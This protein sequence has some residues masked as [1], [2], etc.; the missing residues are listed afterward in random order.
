MCL[1]LHQPLANGDYDAEYVLSGKIVLTRRKPHQRPIVSVYKYSNPANKYR[2]RKTTVDGIEFHSQKEASRYDML[3][4]LERSG[5]ISDLV[6]QP[7]FVIAEGF[8]HDGKTYRT[9]Y[10]VSDFQYLDKSMAVVVED[11]KSPIT[12][13][14]PVYRLKIHLFLSR[15][16]DKYIFVE[17]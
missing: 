10:Y 16:G 5:E 4:I 17:S 3:K 7:R 13:K 2:N 1:K 6:L 12:K 9:R 8:K 11:V 14:N 15:Y